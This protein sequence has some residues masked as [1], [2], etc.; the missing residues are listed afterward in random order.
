M[1]IAYFDCFS[2]LSGDMTLGALL[3]CGVDESVLRDGLAD[4]GVGGYRLE[5]GRRKVEGL[6]STD[7]DVVLTET[8]TG[9]GRHLSDIA[10]IYA[11]SRLSP[12]V[13][14]RAFAIFTRLAEAEAKVH[15]TTPDKIHFHEV[16]AVDAIVDITGACLLLEALGVD[17][18]RCAPLPWTRGFVDCQHGRMPLPAPA[19]VELLAGVPTYPLDV[20]GELVTPTGAAIVATLAG[21]Q[22]FGPPPAMTVVANGWGAGKKDFGTPFPNL[23]RIVI[24]DTAPAPTGGGE[25]GDSVAVLQ[26][27]VDDATP[28]TLGYALERLMDQGALDVMLQPAYMKKNR[29]GTLVTVL[30]TPG[31]AHRLTDLLIAET[32]TFGVRSTQARR[33]ILEREWRT[34]ATEYGDVRVKLG[35]RGGRLLVSAPEHEDCRVAAKAHDVPLRVVHAAALRAMGDAASFRG[36]A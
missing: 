27:Q 21:P 23:L 35:S 9:H 19:T 30:A 6:M 5:I 10:D 20:R 13:R 1:R 22:G 15:G 17:A 11:A 4:L 16:G 18:V 14:E 25:G 2:G 28:E 32:G 24:G 3:A 12:A 26:T 8:D 33:E 34:V 31:D 29:P 7:V 36:G